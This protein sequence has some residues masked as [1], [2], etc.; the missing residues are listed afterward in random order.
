LVER[1]AA[2]GTSLLLDIDDLLDPLEMG[3]QRPAVGLARAFALGLGQRGITRGLRAAQRGLDIFQRQLKLIG[4]E[5]L[6]LAAKP[7]PLERFDDRLQA[8]NP[9]IGLVLG[10]AEIGQCAGLFEDERTERINVIG[11]VRFKEHGR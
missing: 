1:A 3:G 7:V 5:L 8:I 2:T 10:I 9:G 6:G 11:K 4:I